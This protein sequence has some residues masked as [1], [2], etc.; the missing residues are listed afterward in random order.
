[1]KRL[2]IMGAAGLA[3]IAAGCESLFDTTVELPTS[4][5]V[6]SAG[7]E[8][9]CALD[10]D[11]HAFCWGRGENGELGDGRVASSAM[12][13]PVSGE[14]R[15]SAIAVG[16]HHSCAVSTDGVAYCWGW[17][18]YGQLGVG[19][20]VGFGDPAEVVGDLRFSAISAG[21]FHTCALTPEGVAYCWGEN[22]NGQLGTGSAESS[23]IPAEVAGGHRFARISAGEHHTCALTADG[24]A[25]CWGLNHLGQLGDGSIE[26]AWEPRAVAG[27]ISFTAISAGVAH[28][29]AV[30]GNGA[31]YCWEQRLRRAGQYQHR[32]AAPAGSDGA[33]QGL[34][35]QPF[36]RARRRPLRDVRDRRPE[37]GP[38]L[39]RGVYGQLGNGQTVNAATPRFVADTPADL[40]PTRLRFRSID[41]G[42]GH[43]CGVAR[44]WNVYCWGAGDFGQL[45]DPAYPLSMTPVRV[46]DGD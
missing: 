30:S 3:M 18:R 46:R 31:G 6:V 33:L 26:S 1:M 15:Y 2:G 16:R 28:T 10:R 14:R 25:Y 37:S 27:N 43:V 29:C 40:M 38:L 35:R 22:S 12:P 32:D 17:N 7:G 45:G 39:G 21:A 5:A 36:R 13:V 24:K 44:T 8:H 20:T 9:T 41:V 11:G 42:D 23:A 34:R 4:Y 19:S